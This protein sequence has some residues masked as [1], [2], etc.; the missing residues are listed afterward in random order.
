M[1]RAIGPVISRP[2][3]FA[4]IADLCDEFAIGGHRDRRDCVDAAAGRRSGC[5]GA[6]T[7]AVLH[8]VRT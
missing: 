7:P 5:S 1:N 6:G 8:P 4:A 3:S 2:G